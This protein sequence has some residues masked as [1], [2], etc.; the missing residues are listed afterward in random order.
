MQETFQAEILSE[1]VDV[2]SAVVVAENKRV[3]LR[4]QKFFK[5]EILSDDV[6]SAVVA[7]KYQVFDFCKRHFKIEILSEVVDVVSAVVVAE[8]KSFF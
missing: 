7:E 8:N 6:V 3:Y 2:V 4:L 1:V 5:D